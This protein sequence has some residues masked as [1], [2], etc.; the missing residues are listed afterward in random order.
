MP[1]LEIHIKDALLSRI[2]RGNRDDTCHSSSTDADCC[3]YNL[4]IDFDKLGWEWVL[5]PRRIRI[6]YCSGDCQFV[7]RPYY[8]LTEP[9][10]GSPEAPGMKRCCSA[11]SFS[12]VPIL[13]K[14]DDNQTLLTTLNNLVVDRCGCIWPTLVLLSLL[15]INIILFLI[16]HQRTSFKFIHIWYFFKLF[17]PISSVQSRLTNGS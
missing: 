6:N 16:F 10:L 12:P 15:P 5:R 8:R 9:Y 1:I 3:R 2:K 17:W 13:Y 11:K 14:A 4:V 7:Q